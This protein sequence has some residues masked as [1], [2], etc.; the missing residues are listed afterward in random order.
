[1]RP[2]RLGYN[3]AAGTPRHQD[4]VRDD[5]RMRIK[6][7]SAGPV[8]ILDLNGRMTRNDGCGEIRTAL[9]PLL[10]QGHTQFLL[11]LADVPYMDSTG[12]GELV[13]VFITAR[14]HKGTL[15][16]VALTGRM[17]ELFEVAKLV[18]VLD[19]F[20]DEADALQSF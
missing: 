10:E 2:G 4:P 19:V 13:S 11:N 6:Q 17:R 5:T 3:G 7:R 16:L 18:K 20:D 9:K 12:I 8:T 15:K 1:M 14:N